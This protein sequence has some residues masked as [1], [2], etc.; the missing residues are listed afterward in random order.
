[1]THDEY[2]QADKDAVCRLIDWLWAKRFRNAKIDFDNECC[3]VALYD[4]KVITVKAI[5]GDEGTKSLAECI[6]EAME[7]VKQ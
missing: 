4:R 7:Q 1:M 2:K 5:N 3:E 6:D